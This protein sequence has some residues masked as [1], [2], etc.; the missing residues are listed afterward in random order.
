MIGQG[1]KKNKATEDLNTNYR[2]DLMDSTF[3]SSTHG[4]STEM[5]KKQKTEVS[6]G[7]RCYKHRRRMSDGS[8]S[9][10]PESLHWG[11]MESR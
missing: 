8:E 4:T 10:R 7:S 9:Q 2:V 5:N 11:V 3:L 1:A 6:I